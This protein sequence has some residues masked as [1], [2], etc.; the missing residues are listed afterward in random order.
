MGF[1]IQCTK[2]PKPSKFHYISKVN[3]IKSPLKKLIYTVV[4]DVMEIQNR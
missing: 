3:S 1:F 4:Y 2:Y